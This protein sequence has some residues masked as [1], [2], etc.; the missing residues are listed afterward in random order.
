M[1]LQTNQLQDAKL[2]TLAEKFLMVILF[3]SFIDLKFYGMHLMALALLLYCLK[4][5]R[6]TISGGIIPL[7]ILTLSMFFFLKNAFQDLTSIVRCIVWPLAFLLGYCLIKDSP[8][9]KTAELRTISLIKLSALGFFCHYALNGILNFGETDLG[10]DTLD[11]WTNEPM[12]ATVQAAMACIPA[13]WFVSRLVSAHNLMSRLLPFL[14]LAAIMYYNL[15]L[16]TRF[17]LYLYLVLAIV[18]VLYVLISVSNTRRK[19]NTLLF[20]LALIVLLLILYATNTWGLQTLVEESILSQRYET[21][22]NMAIADDSRWD[23]KLSY[24][25]LMPT[26]LWGGDHIQAKL[27]SFSHDIFLDTYSDA[28]IFALLGVIILLWNSISVLFRLLRHADLSSSTKL[29]FLS[30][31][32]AILLEFCIEPIIEGVPLLLMS[33]CF[34]HGLLSSL[35]H[36]TP[37]INTSQITNMKA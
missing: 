26:Y 10:R 4:Q 18:S 35:L 6:L 2:F 7:V 34:F 12:A 13:A 24:L 21:N 15:T 16:G 22:D 19:Q 9:A 37:V 14:G 1:K 27:G 8:D 30:V 29:I 23:S 36:H 25:K 28:G 11:I 31:Y 33:F 3:L 20:V 5:G 17:L 32:T